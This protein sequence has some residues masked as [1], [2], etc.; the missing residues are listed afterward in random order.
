MPFVPKALDIGRLYTRPQLADMWGYATYNAIA[1]GVVTPRGGG[2]IILFVTRQKQEALTQY[3]DFISGDYL[4]WE[5]EERHGS[6]QRIARAH[7]NG[8]EVHLF[9]R[10]IHHTPFRYHG[11][12]LLIHFV[13]QTTGPSEF[14]FRLVHDLSPTDD[15]QAHQ[16][17]MDAVPETERLRL[18]KARLGQGDFR[19]DLLRFW[20]SC[21]VTGIASPDLLRASHIKPWRN[22]TNEERLDRFNGLLLL[23]Q[24]DHLFDRGY[25]TFDDDGRLIPSPAIVTLPADR[26]GVD[27]QARLRRL[28]DSH[29][30]FLR[31]HREQVFWGEA[32]TD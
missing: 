31:F 9:Y 11:P 15:V 5:G 12:V 26:L 1:R 7:E 25:I 29:L 24:Y 19:E 22:S 6:D 10:D 8:E 21:A 30:P 28:D 2:Y 20:R 16:A 27:M 13:P 14:A 3:R 23:P 32:A 17:E 4:H 18:V